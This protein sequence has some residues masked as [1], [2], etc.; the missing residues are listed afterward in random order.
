MKKLCFLAIF[1]LVP[2]SA[3]A[4]MPY[5][6]EVKALGSV[7]GQGM[8]CGASK[9]DTYEMLARAILLT[10][11]PTPRDLNEAAYT[12]NEAKANAYVSKQMDG[13]YQCAEINQRFNSQDIFNITLYADGTLK[14][15]D[16]KVITPV[17]PYD[18]NQIY[19]SD[20][21]VQIKAKAIYEGA[22]AR[23]ADPA[24]APK[25]ESIKPQISKPVQ[26]PQPQPITPQAE[27]AVENGDTPIRH[28]RR[29][30]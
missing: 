28:I 19:K 16:G 23:I 10:K 14:M 11:A 6:E 5:L 25:F 15:P 9:F 12:Y 30:N 26:L 29:R 18:A 27:T 22:P 20:R 8:A 7:S 24:Q 17:T 4:Q 1:S 3:F 2:A 13:F 21:N